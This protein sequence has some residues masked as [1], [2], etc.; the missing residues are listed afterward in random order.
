MTMLRRL[1]TSK[2][3]TTLFDL[4][5]CVSLREHPWLRTIVDTRYCVE[6][7][8]EMYELADNRIDHVVA[9]V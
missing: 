3:A 4:E 9:T 7:L 8:S 6:K 1:F 2:Q 5:D